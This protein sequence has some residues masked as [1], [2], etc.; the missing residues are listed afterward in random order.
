MKKIIL[1]AILLICFVAGIYGTYA[2]LTASETKES[3]F[4]IGDIQLTLDETK[5]DAYGVPTGESA[6]VLQNNYILVPAYRYTKDP[7]VHLQANSED[8]WLFAYIENGLESIEGEE[9]VSEQLIEN[10]WNKLNG[11]DN[12]Y[13]RHHSTSKQDQDYVL[14]NYFT[15]DEQ[16]DTKAIQEHAN[17]TIQVIVYAIQSKGLNDPHTA[18]L[19]CLRQNDT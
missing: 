9:T 11:V 8:C 6:R 16:T 4:V 2:Y 15:I 13:Y 1:L 10:K 17:Q 12:V 7:T 14:F 19:T 18:F 5:T 3:T